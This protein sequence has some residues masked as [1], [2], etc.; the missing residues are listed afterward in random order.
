MEPY[1]AIQPAFT[2][3]ELSE[4]VSN[5]VDLDKYQLGLKQAQNAIIRPYGSVHKRPG[6]I[7]CGKTKYVGDEKIVRLQEFDFLTDLSY[8]L[9]FGDKYLRIW[10]D[11]IYLGVELA[12]PFA[13]GDLS[14]LRFTQSVDVMYICSGIYPVQKLSRYAED[15]WELTEAE[16]ETPPFCD[17]NKDTA[18]TIQPSGKTGTVTLTASKGIFSSD[19]IGDTIKLDQYVDGRSVETTNG[20]SSEILVGK[21]W[22][23]ITHGTWT[24]TV[25]VQYCG[26]KNHLPN[27][28]WKTLRTYTSSDDYNPSE[29]GDVEE[30]TYMRIHASISSGTCKANLSS[31]PYTHTG[32][33]KIRSV[34]NTTTAVGTADWLGSTDATE[35]WYW[36]AWSKTNGYPYC[37][38]FFQD[39][40]VFGGSPGEPQRVWMSRSGDY[41]DFSIDK[42]SGTVTDDSAV[43]A[44]L[45]SRKACAINHMD[46]GNDL[47]VFT[48]GNSWTISGSETV[49]PS[50]ITPRNQENYGVSDIAPLRVGNR[51]VYIQRRGSVVRDTGYDYNTDS[52][53]GTD[54]TLLSKDL[55][56]GQTI[57]DDAFAQ[58]PDSL[59]YF[60]RADGVMLVLTYVMDQK[61]YA[62]SHL[63]TDGIFESVASVNCGNR[64]DVYVVVRRTIGTQQV[65]CI[66]R[67]DR[68][69]VS[70]NQQDYIMLD[71]AVIYDLDQAASVITGLENLEGKT[72]R[73]LADQYLYD[74]MTVQGGKITLPDGV[75]AKRLVIGLPYTM[76]LEQPNWDV[77]NM[78]S[79]TVQGRNKTVT[80]AILRLKNSFG[81][82]IG[83]DADHLQEIIYDPQ[84][85]E[86]G[87]KVLTTGDRTVTL[88]E[89]GV[90]T[91]GR[92]YIYHETPYPFT[93]SA[94]IRAVTFLG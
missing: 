86:T 25:Q 66:E 56:N 30:Y 93:L 42:E 37:A 26:E 58:E 11:G 18:C 14:R 29:S 81:G 10:R 44:D 69:R 80:K 63:V 68:D 57:V 78:Q 61:V 72:V 15:D 48:E 67:F 9:E 43:T 38:T 88:H 60:V 6:L 92:T 75:S 90:N 71:S 84:R 16:W 24:G 13:S 45:L 19:N 33:V 28:D 54:L 27:Q 70:D 49:T 32:Y 21:T 46:A 91:E 59:L 73:V 23:V 17:V 62:W 5:R 53:A 35:D 2:G 50:S 7:Y 41:E 64:D 47:I 89:K 77:G 20:T 79:G 82:W 87:E 3:G 22:K 52:Y 12:T 94:I 1:Y 76:I 4:D 36:P 40:L 51:V 34:N 39:R 8:L 74:P 31:Y 85:M 65:R 83:P 55:I